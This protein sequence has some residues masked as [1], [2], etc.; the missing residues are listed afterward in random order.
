MD[1]YIIVLL[2]ACGL[3]GFFRRDFKVVFRR[4]GACQSMPILNVNVTSVLGRV[5]MVDGLV[6]RC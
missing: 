2:K 6:S 1:N 3:I 4:K 5:V